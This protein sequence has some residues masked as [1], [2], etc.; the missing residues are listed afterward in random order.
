MSAMTKVQERGQVT[1][2]KQ[3]RDAAHIKPGDIVIFRVIAPGKVE[4]ESF[5]PK[6]LEWWWDNY[7]YDGPLT[8]DEI[9]KL[10]EGDM[11]SDAWVD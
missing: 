9:M 6:P 2:P 10:A 1:L 7:T 8:V 11:V 5:E 4:M 3:I